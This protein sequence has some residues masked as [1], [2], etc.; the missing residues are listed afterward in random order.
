MK[1]SIEEFLRTGRFGPIEIGIAKCEAISILGAP[2][3]EADLGET[4][5]ILLYAWYELFFNHEE[6]LCSIQ[7][8]N[9]N[10]EIKDS[11]SFSNDSFQIDPWFLNDVKNKN[12]IDIS[13]LLDEKCIEYQ[14]VDYYGRDVLKLKCGVIVDF[15]EDNN[16]CGIKP[17][18]GIRFWP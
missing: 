6:T 12:I 7:N 5:S 3:S 17:L 4:G 8:D 1:I 10:P 9:Y 11:Y 16:E 13:Q 14:V 2:D 15:E 18:S